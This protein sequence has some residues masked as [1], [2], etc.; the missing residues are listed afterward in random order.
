MDERIKQIIVEEL[1]KAEVNGIV[2]GKLDSFLNSKEFKD[3]VKDISAK[4]I[5]ELYKVLWTRKTF[6]ADLIKK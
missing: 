2:S 4:V 5:E 3:K 6:W 1:T